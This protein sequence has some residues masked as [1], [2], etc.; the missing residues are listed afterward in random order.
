M[1]FVIYKRPRT[2]KQNAGSE[3]LLLAGTEDRST[4]GYTEI[5][6]DARV[7]PAIDQAAITAGEKDQVAGGVGAG[8]A[9][10]G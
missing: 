7:V 9:E 8:E 3:E 10:I 2:R 6:E 4:T 1:I 5:L